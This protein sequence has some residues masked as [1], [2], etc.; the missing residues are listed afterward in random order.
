MQLYYRITKRYIAHL[1][2]VDLLLM[3]KEYFLFVDL[4]KEED[5]KESINYKDKFIN[6]STFQWQTPNSTSQNSDRGKI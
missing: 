1:E 4:H 3:K 5:I 6:K 2:E